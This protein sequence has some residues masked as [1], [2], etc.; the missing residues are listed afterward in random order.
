MDECQR[1]LEDDIADIKAELEE[2]KKN[3]TVVDGKLYSE[4]RAMKWYELFLNNPLNSYDRIIVYLI[5]FR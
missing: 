3:F 2:V 1:T 4:L 5:H